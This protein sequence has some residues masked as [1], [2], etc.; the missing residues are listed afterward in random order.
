MS[1]LLLSLGNRLE[2]IE[3]TNNAFMK[4]VEEKFKSFDNRI[5]RMATNHKVL[6]GDLSIKLIEGSSA[7]SPHIFEGFE[8]DIKELRDMHYFLASSITSNKR[9]RSDESNKKRNAKLQRKVSSS[10]ISDDSEDEDE[11]EGEIYKANL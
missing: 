1:E 8:K 5:K 4:R 7:I 9:S 6:Y 2:K 11:D 3:E 10:D